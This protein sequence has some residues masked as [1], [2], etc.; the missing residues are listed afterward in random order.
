MKG[1]VRLHISQNTA[2]QTQPPHLAFQSTKAPLHD[3][4][5]E[6]PCFSS[7]LWLR[8]PCHPFPVRSFSTHLSLP[9]STFPSAVGKYFGFTFMSFGYLATSFNG[10]GTEQLVILC[11]ASDDNC[12]KTSRLLRISTTRWT[13]P[14]HGRTRDIPLSFPVNRKS[15]CSHCSVRHNVLER[16]DGQ[17][18]PRLLLPFGAYRPGSLKNLLFSCRQAA[19][20]PLPE[21]C[22]LF[23][24]CYNSRW[25]KED[26]DNYLVTASDCYIL[27]PKAMKLSEDREFESLW[28]RGPV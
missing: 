22:T 13:R 17:V 10:S 2:T 26:V 7:V 27:N 5:N 25:S 28:D 19:P 20:I 9:W 16:N 15:H 24:S 3:S 21:P 18:Q 14:L 23:L 1:K 8:F 11:W 6:L 12:T 4:P